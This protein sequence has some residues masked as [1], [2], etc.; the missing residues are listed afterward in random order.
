MAQQYR[1]PRLFFRQPAHAPMSC[2]RQRLTRSLRTY[3]G[4]W[5]PAAQQ[6]LVPLFRSL[7]AEHALIWW[8]GQSL[9]GGL[10]GGFGCG[11]IV[12]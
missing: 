8:A 11:Y 6:F 5:C 10:C 7:H 1:V 3:A 9:V 12:S 4:L 2:C